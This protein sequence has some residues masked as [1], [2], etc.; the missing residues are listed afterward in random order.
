MICD[1]HYDYHHYAYHFDRKFIEASNGRGKGCG[2]FSL[3][4]RNMSNE[5]TVVKE[6]YQLLS[7]VDETDPNYTYQVILV[8]ASS[9]C[10]LSEVVHHLSHLLFPQMKKI[11][12]GD[13]NY[14]KKET[15]ILTTFLKNNL[16]S[17]VVP[18]PTHIQGR[19]LDHCY[20]SQNI[21]VQLTRYSPY[22]SDHSAL[23]IEFEFDE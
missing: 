8:Y 18:W 10:N 4:S 16:L 12:I 23:C 13:F 3:T 22:Y 1:Y 14:D 15:N 6:N 2:M 7:V 20:V 9:G 19:T 17:Q 11:V 5:V 21:E